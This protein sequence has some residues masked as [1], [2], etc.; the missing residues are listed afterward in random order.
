[1]IK[2]ILTV[3]LMLVGF[4]A[5]AESKIT[6]D[7]TRYCDGYN[8]RGFMVESDTF[9][10]LEPYLKETEYKVLDPYA[11]SDS[12]P[13]LL[14]AEK[15][16]SWIFY[17]QYNL[18]TPNLYSE[19]YIEYTHQNVITGRWVRDFFQLKDKYSTPVYMPD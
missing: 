11:A 19:G 10:E 3:L 5:F 2:K 6:W 16:E 8:R 13:L 15:K 1:M 7:T 14:G 12:R 4:A 17:I 9:K 18:N